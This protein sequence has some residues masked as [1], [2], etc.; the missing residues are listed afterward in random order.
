LQIVE[1]NDKDLKDGMLLLLAAKL[2]ETDQG[3]I[4]TR[5]L[6]KIMSDDWGFYYT[7]TTNLGKVKQHMQGVPALTD[8][9]RKIITAKAD[10][11]LD[12]IEKAPK[13]GNWKRRA[14]VGTKKPW[15][16]EVSD[17]A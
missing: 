9:H 7:A 17:W 3:L 14:Q 5:Y 6:G 1:I 2:G 12:A 10:A 8:E 4:N 13:S 11:L 15:Y 16:N